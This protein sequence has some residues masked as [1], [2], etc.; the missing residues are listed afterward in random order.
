MRCPHTPWKSS[1]GGSYTVIFWRDRV[2]FAESG[3]C[4]DGSA[5]AEI[6]FRHKERPGKRCRIPIHS[7]IMMGSQET[8]HLPFS[9]SIPFDVSLSRGKRAMPREFLD[10]AKRSTGLRDLLAPLVIKVRRPECELAPV[11]PSS[12]NRV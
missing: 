1:S 6:D 11:N 3:N 12:A 10:I 4:F 8:D 2:H 7:K 9:V 5:L